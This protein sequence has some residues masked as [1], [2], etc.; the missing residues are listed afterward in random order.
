MSAYDKIKGLNKEIEL[1][2]HKVQQL[3]AAKADLKRQLVSAREDVKDV[4]RELRGARNAIKY[5]KRQLRETQYG[6]EE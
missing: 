3:S 4:K 5:L 2:E 1:L 6:K